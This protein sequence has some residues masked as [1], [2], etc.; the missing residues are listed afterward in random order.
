LSLLKKKN[1]HIFCVFVFFWNFTALDN[2][3]EA[4]L[5]LELNRP[6]SGCLDLQRKSLKKIRKLFSDL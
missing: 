1:Q 5:I 6:L 2:W 3:E 4:L